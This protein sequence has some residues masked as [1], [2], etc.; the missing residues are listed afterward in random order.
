MQND[1]PREDL[2]KIFN[3]GLER[4]KGRGA[5]CEYL[6]N[7]PL[8]AQQ[9]HLVAIGKAAASM[10]LGAMDILGERVVSG[11]LITK[12]NHL[13]YALTTY[14][15][16]TCLE[17]DHPVPGRASLVAGQALLK[18][19][20]RHAQ[21]DACIIFLLSGGTSSLVEVLAEGADL[22]D[23]KDLTQ[24]L[25]AHGLDIQKINAVRRSISRI[26]G[27]RLATF[28]NGAQTLVLLISDVPGDNPGVIGSGLLTAVHDA[29][30]YAD[31]PTAVIDILNRIDTVAVP[32]A[33]TFDAVQTRIVACLEDAKADCREAAIAMGY[34]ARCANCFVE[35]DTLVA[36]KRIVKEVLD[37]PEQVLIFGGETCLVLPP[38][39]GAGGRN[40]HLALAAA[41]MLAH[42][43]GIYLLSAGTDGTDGP[44]AAAGGLV[45]ST[46]LSRGKA[47]GLDAQQSLAA[48]DSHTYLSAIGDALISGPTGTNVMDLIIGLKTD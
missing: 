46:T 24:L 36:A 38:E 25:L 34:S 2:I 26:K 33:E 22:D 12:H 17:S 29:V 15:Q 13:D 48:A 47:A 5:V 11:L 9:T 6:K 44:T 23:L 35:G 32:C 10:T 42:T 40:Q 28:L 41:L 16:I 1:K 7:A 14:P 4:V 31:Y 45:D 21:N 39:P 3:A 30:E 8:D 18:Y 20:A 19:L 43:Q 37:A 27:G